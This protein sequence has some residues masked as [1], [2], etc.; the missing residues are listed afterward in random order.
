[1]RAVKRPRARAG[2]RVAVIG[3]SGQIGSALLD[4]LGRRYRVQGFDLAP[5]RRGRRLDIVG[6]DAPRALRGFDVLC[7]LAARI[8]TDG[9]V[10]DPRGLTETNVLGVV[11]VLEAARRNDARLI[12]ASSVAV[13]GD[14]SEV[15]IPETQALRPLS[16]YGLS[17]LVGEQYVAHYRE[18]YGLDAA[19][20]RPFNVYSD[21]TGAGL[22]PTEVVGLLLGRAR[23]SKPL[24]VS[25]DGQQTRD[26]VHVSDVVRLFELLVQGRGRGETLNAGTGTPTRIIDLAEW[27]RDAVNPSLPIVHAPART[28]DVRNSWANI[29]RARSLGFAPTVQIRDWLRSSGRRHHRRPAERTGR[30]TS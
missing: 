21:R 11:Q 27:V 8:P 25:G 4:G 6:T 2:P 22:P 29:E 30:G 3:S 24:V 14:P 13:Y 9:A 20:V 18:V 23:A 15:P 12:F 17:K 16:L 1:M 28:R 10:S 26:F 19:I 5:G 7:H